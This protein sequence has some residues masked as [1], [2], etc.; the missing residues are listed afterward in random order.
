MIVV[1][2]DLVRRVVEGG[3]IRRRVVRPVRRETVEVVVREDVLERRQLLRHGFH[4]GELLGVLAD[5]SHRSGVL[6]EV[7]H[8]AR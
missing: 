2:A 3:R 1:F 6:Q 7:A 5:D 4:L 8:V